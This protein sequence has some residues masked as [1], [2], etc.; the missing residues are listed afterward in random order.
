[1]RAKPGWKN[2]IENLLDNAFAAGRNTLFEHEVYRI[3][4]LHGVRT[5]HHLLVTRPDEITGDVLSSF[6]CQKLVLKI[7]TPGITHK[8]KAGGVQIIY[9]DLDFV[10][11]SCTKM[12]SDFNNGGF[13]VH[14]VLLAELIDYSK[15]LGNEILL[16][17]RESES[18]GPVLSISKGGRDAEH[19]AA[20]FSEPNIV[21]PPVNTDWASA[22]LLSTRIHLKY[23]S[24]G[25]ESY[26]RHIVKAEEI[27]SDISV[28][29][30][31]FFP[32][33]SA[34]AISELEINPFVFDRNDNFIAIDGFAS[35]EKKRT[36]RPNLRLQS[37]ATLSGFF[38]PKGI[39]L[40][41]IS[42]SDDGKAG[43]IIFQNLMGL[44]RTDV[45]CVNPKGG[46][47]KTGGYDSPLYKNISEI[48]ENID[49]AVITVPAEATL[50]VV[51]ECAEKGIKA[52]LLIPGGFSET[53]SNR[54]IEDRILEIAAKHSM[55][56]MGPNC[57][58][59]FHVGSPK[60][61]GINTFFIPEEKFRI[62]LN[63]EQSVALLSQSGGLGVMEIYNLRNSVSPRVIVSYG[64]QIDIDPS[65]LVQYF[66]SDR[67]IDVIGLYIEGFKPGAGRKF[68]DT[69]KRC[70]TPIIVYKAGRTEEGR[71]ATQSHTASISGEYAVA[72]A[73]MKQ[74]GLVVADTLLDHGDLLKTF[75]LL[76]DFPVNG[77]RVAVIANAGYEKTYAADSLYDLIPAELDSPTRQRLN[78]TLPSFVNIEPFLDL[79]PMVSDA[80][81]EKC[82]NIVLSSECVDCLCISIVPQ[83]QLIHTTDSEIE[84]YKD[85]IAHR[86]V[87]T[88][89][90]YQKPVV[91]SINVVSGSD[92][93]YNKFGQILDRGGVPTFLSAGRAMF[94]LNEFIRYHTLRRS[95]AFS[96]WLRQ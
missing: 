77:S 84:N 57:L 39:V 9:K 29:F 28:E 64:N 7:V 72:K 63:R 19:F 59:V 94:C 33:D 42:S 25:K 17:F 73:A 60:R 23:E 80:Q 65:D 83:A 58:G 76:S 44:S 54:D 88:I 1:V 68:F 21:L 3:L 22:L 27:L 82:I 30:S 78:E 24:E 69:T 61:K 43:N 45:Y 4:E 41:G 81:Y 53:G 34:Y 89:H 46:R 15:D 32:S 13:T 95:S 47:L 92:A 35:F 16:G 14:G 86:I 62:E 87:K 31:N 67:S 90:K 26:I 37:K 12:L 48:G 49:L 70:R 36:L 18:F 6:G 11:Y 96:E 56:I 79:T 93:V 91:I 52:V 75:A 40:V 50:S 66:E 2:E 55:R 51:E 85:N 38:N 74:A 71:L 20:N 5:P 10:R 8:Q